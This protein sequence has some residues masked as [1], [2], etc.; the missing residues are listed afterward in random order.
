MHGGKGELPPPAQRHLASCAVCEREARALRLLILGSGPA[1]ERPRAGFGDRLR[2][3]RG[4]LPATTTVG[5]GDALRVSRRPILALVLVT[6]LLCV[7]F[8]VAMPAAPPPEDR[9]AT[10]LEGDPVL[11]LVA[12][13]EPAAWLTAP[14]PDSATAGY[15]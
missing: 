13:G 2:V 7:G 1:G 14:S 12:T 3:R 6:A 5:F 10:L 15:E 9:I 4:A 8:L 11:R